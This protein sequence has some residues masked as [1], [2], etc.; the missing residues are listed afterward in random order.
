[1][2]TNITLEGGTCWNTG[3]A[4]A[5]PTLFAIIYLS[6]TIWTVVLSRVLLKQNMG[7]RWL[8]ICGMFAGPTIIGFSLNALGLDV[9]GGCVQQPSCAEW[10]IDAPLSHWTDACEDRTFMHSVNGP[11]GSCEPRFFM[12]KTCEAKTKVEWLVCLLYSFVGF[13]LTFTTF[14][15]LAEVLRGFSMREIAVRCLLELT[16]HHGVQ[17]HNQRDTFGLLPK[18]NLDRIGNIVA[19]NRMRIVLQTWESKNF[20]QEQKRAALVLLVLFAVLAAQIY[21][22][23]VP[24]DWG[25]HSIIGTLSREYFPR[26]FNYEDVIPSPALTSV[27]IKTLMLQL[28][29]SGLA[30]GI[31]WKGG[32]ACHLY[33]YELPHLLVLK[34]ADLQIAGL[35]TARSLMYSSA[36]ELE[37]WCKI[38]QEDDRTIGFRNYLI[39]HKLHEIV[40]RVAVRG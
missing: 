15:A 39:E 38:D 11:C 6:A 27:N 34:K 26:R 20:E 33:E 36:V 22:W 18:F 2:S 16:P 29:G 28:L 32:K 4:I 19:W 1:M 40:A 24:S 3:G 5:G 8:A 35:P 37:V 12:F 17:S 13:E 14:S 25:G 31:V 21:L 9:F 23:F 30:F 7:T 10:T